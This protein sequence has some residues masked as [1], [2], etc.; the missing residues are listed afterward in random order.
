MRIAAWLQGLLRTRR[1]DLRKPPPRRYHDELFPNLFVR[2]LEDRR[3]LN[4]TALSWDHGAEEATI[5]AGALANDGLTDTFHVVR[6]GDEVQIS[7]NGREVYA[8]PLADLENITLNGSRDS[9]TLI[10]DF[11]GGDP[12][13]AGGLIFHGMDGGQDCVLAEGGSSGTLI[14]TVT[15]R[16]DRVGDGFLHVTWAGDQT[17]SAAGLVYTGVESMVDT[18]APD[19]LVFQFASAAETVTISDDG[20]LGDGL[21]TISSTGGT[22]V[23]FAGPRASLVVETDVP[24]GGS[25]TVNVDGLDADPVADLTIR[26]D[27]GDTLHFA[28]EID[29]GG[30]SLAATGGTIRVDGAIASQGG[31]V[32]LDAGSGGALLVSGT[33]DVS[34][35]AP[36]QTGGTVHLLGDQV[37]L[38]GGAHVD[39]SGD[40]GGGTILIGGDYQGN[41]PDVGN[42]TLTVIAPEATIRA[43]ALTHGDGGRVIVWA[44]DSTFFYGRLTARGG[45]ESGEGGFA[46]ISGKVNLVQRGSV[47]LLAPHG[48]TG[49]LLLDPLDIRIVGG[50]ADGHDDPDAI[51]TALIHAA[52]S[53][54]AGTIA[55]GDEGSGTPNPFLVYESEIEAQSA[56]ANII[57]EARNSITVSG[58]FLHDGDGAGSDDPGFNVVL[59][60]NGNSLVLRTRNDTGDGIGGIDLTGSVA[61]SNL[62][63]RTT[64]SG[65][66]TIETGSDG[67]VGG[68]SAP[69]A[70]PVTL[71]TL[72]TADGDVHVSAEG[73]LN[74]NGN[75][76]AGGDGEIRLVT[77]GG[78]DIH[79]RANVVDVGS[80]NLVVLDSS[81]AVTQMMGTLI[82]AQSLRLTADNAIGS[83]TSSSAN[84]IMVSV[85]NLSA[86]LDGAAATGRIVIA[87][88]DDLNV[89]AVDGQSG[90]TTSNGNDVGI[91]SC[92]GTI[93]VLYAVTTT[94]S[95]RIALG[96]MNP[97]SMDPADLDLSDLNS[98]G[99]V[100]LYADVRTDSGD[101]A[102]GARNILTYGTA[103]ITQTTGGG[104][105]LLVA[106]EGIG[107]AA[108]PLRIDVDTVAAVLP[109]S[110]SGGVYLIQV[111]GYHDD[112]TIGTFSLGPVTVHGVVTLGNNDIGVETE[113]GTLTVAR[114]VSSLGSG[115]VTLVANGASSDV[116]TATGTGDVL[117]AT[118]D[119]TMTAGRAI[120]LGGLVATGGGTV[121][122][123][124]GAGDTGLLALA[125]GGVASGGGAIVI[126][127]DDLAILT[128]APTVIDAGAGRV[129]I[130]PADTTDAARTIDLGSDTPGRLGITADELARISTTGVLQI[131][132]SYAGDVTLSNSVISAGFTT[133]RIESSGSLT[134]TAEANTIAVDALAIEVDGDVGASGSRIT[135][136]V[137]SLAVW[138]KVAG[139][140]YLAET[141]A[142]VTVATVDGL[143]GIT[144][145]GSGIDLTVV[146]DLTI[147]APITAG[148]DG[149]VRLVT[150]G[151]GDIR[152][153]ANVT[154]VG[155][156]NLV[157]LDADGRINDGTSNRIEAQSLRLTAAEGIGT[158]AD[159]VLTEVANL[160]AKLDSPAATGGI[161]LVEK[162]AVSVTTVD[163]QS[164]INTTNDQSVLLE[165]EAGTITLLEN[166]TADRSGNVTLSAKGATSDVEVNADVQ[167]G[168]GDLFL[169]AGRSITTDNT[170]RI[171]ATTDGSGTLRLD[172]VDAIGTST[173][174]IEIDVATVA[175]QITGAATTGDVFLTQ[176]AGH[177]GDLTIGSASGLDGISTANNNDVAVETQAGSLTIA[178][179]VAAHG[180]GNVTLTA[181][182]AASDIEVNADVQ[183]ADGDLL[184]DA[185]RSITTD[186]TGTLIATT[187][188]SGT[189]RLDAV[190]AIG[191]A[192]NPLQTDVATVAAQITGAATTGDV[193]LNQVD[194]QQDDLTIGSAGGLD[195]ITT[196]NNNDVTVETQAGTLTVAQPVVADGSGNV[197][198]TA[199]GP[200]SDLVTNESAGDVLSGTGRID[201]AAGQAIR[202][203]DRVE[204]GGGSITLATGTGDTGLLTLTSGGATPG[205]IASGGGPVVI[206]ADDLAI[207]NPAGTAID[208]GSGRVTI[209]P[210]DSADAARQID[211]GSNAAG[212]LGITDAELDRITTT[213][214][215]EIGE[216]YA[217]DVMLTASLS[218]QNFGTL[219]INSSGSLTTTAEANTI[220]VDNLVIEVDNDIGAN[221]ARISTA[222]T[223]LAAASKVSG[224]VFLA[225][226]ADGLTVT[227]VDGLSGI[228]VTASDLDL[229]VVGDLTIAA[230][231]ANFSPTGYLSLAAGNDVAVGAQVKAA[232][233]VALHAGGNLHVPDL[234]S[235]PSGESELTG[236]SITADAGGTIIIDDQAVLQSAT[237][238][239]TNAPPLLRIGEKDPDKVIV[240]GDALQELVG[241][242]GGMPPGDNLELGENF[243]IT[244]TWDDGVQN[245]VAGVNSSQALSMQVAQDGTAAVNVVDD[246]TNYIELDVSREYPVDYLNT[247]TA[248]DLFATVEVRND[249]NIR[250]SD[251]SGV[252]LN[253]V[254]AVVA[255]S[256]AGQQST[257]PAAMEPREPEPIAAREAPPAPLPELGSVPPQP[258]SRSEEIRV[259]REEIVEDERKIYIV[260]VGPDGS[261][262][263][264]QSLPGDALSSLSALLE[265]FK[266]SA[267]EGKEGLPNGLYRI[268]LEEVGFPRRK[269]ME[270]YKSGDTLGEQVRPPG[271]GSMPIPDQGS[272]TPGKEEPDGGAANVPQADGGHD[273]AATPPPQG[274]A[275][276]T[277]AEEA[278]APPGSSVDDPDPA[279]DGAYADVDVPSHRW[280]RP[281]GGAA[282]LAAGSLAAYP[283]L[284]RWQESIDRAMADSD[285]KSFGKAA[286]LRR[287][288]LR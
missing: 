124:T 154:D 33:I 101:L 87:E 262:G 64:G 60:Q 207:D 45:A 144:T 20:D 76:M 272:E 153:K 229:T 239:V 254:S 32:E 200:A 104:T 212:R 22:A 225:E 110:A 116:V 147:S 189:L 248:N 261:E 86:A 263:E 92:T 194:G 244:V 193:F 250:L 80:D 36:G 111:D 180:S 109:D 3:V 65:S 9:D 18:T 287:R 282:V 190:D 202:L 135:T 78:G 267:E 62:V 7:V 211:L 73:T 246:G 266:G 161:Y 103:T 150:T 279:G 41:N 53:N 271:R 243:T 71:G 184:L 185:G 129:T 51:A 228:T 227:T 66:I 2:Q 122:L 165:T 10:V 217:G 241:S 113:A 95:G 58:V 163:G 127:A 142:G 252:D 238:K 182:G 235:L 50:T 170:G 59:I 38:V 175:A 99:D 208:A 123:N 126:S 167:T 120:T 136:R 72:V 105:L 141:A 157:V 46:E 213:G 255:T 230:S 82:V 100:V 55:L 181:K 74:V 121:T 158:A 245:V 214:V 61:S 259:Q 284:G 264:R 31:S 236:G 218:P 203:S 133:L 220:A 35:A 79:V 42:A 288:F 270:F 247:V 201:L 215:V 63:F 137:A 257:T 173:N 195:G 186:G 204:T 240:P 81:D 187:D 12:F 146:G 172:A 54:T 166:V 278:A 88:L 223:N 6:Q 28:G 138:S 177:Q 112:L 265:K 176:V 269:V 226:T 1:S 49:T 171:V 131:G 197:M 25:D 199:N 139:D 77:T 256:F 8:A 97:A 34:D 286:R 231:I 192:A 249:P 162:D 188:G 234:P 115:N 4:G 156:D 118:G 57:L 268:Y 106:T 285:E 283:A 48:A 280:V 160:S 75:V 140:V 30:R 89:T 84:P 96:S 85:E 275:P 210:A 145:T 108:E 23:T 219:R 56:T 91:G 70:A 114:P 119:V 16:F 125:G 134:T 93:T 155:S 277:S 13:P 24:G 40:A 68:G 273:P 67:A 132:D 107:T 179:N 178:Q 224:G 27:A 5:D 19:R 276:A 43:D 149:D 237:G 117:S 169:D 39:A 83:A 183:T 221:G 258:P 205:S 130:R 90:V 174:R 260:K 17:G 198:L 191:T 152:V 94:G 47:D 52:G 159:P 206:N 151:G 251:S 11:S 148:G 29:L 44:D 222:V 232:G 102:I 15:H 143:S 281:G 26:G 128:P 69:G 216:T 233:P 168:T 253:R 209:R 196:A 98:T 21:S 242:A 274:T 14:D 37:T 164:G